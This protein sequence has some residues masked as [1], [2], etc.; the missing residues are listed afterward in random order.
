MSSTKVEQSDGYTNAQA[1]NI[2]IIGC[3]RCVQG[4]TE[5]RKGTATDL[6]DACRSVGF[7]Y[8]VNHGISLSTI[9]ETFAWSRRLFDLDTSKE[10]LAPYPNGSAV[11]RG[12]S[13]PGLEKVSQAFGDD[14]D[15]DFAKK[16]RSITNVK[17]TRARTSIKFPRST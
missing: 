1:S 12:Y 7:A 16:L 3:S 9:K 5:Q 13:W 15:P 17:V 4:N 10:V 11:H 2:P 14:D 8:I 6:I